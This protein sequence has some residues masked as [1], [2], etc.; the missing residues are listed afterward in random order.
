MSPTPEQSK[1]IVLI[2]GINGYIASQCAKAFLEAGYSVRGTV[3]QLSSAQHLFT[4]AFTSYANAGKFEVAEVRDITVPGAFD[5]AVKGVSF[6]LHAASP[7]G[8]S[9][10]DP[11]PILHTAVVGT[12]T[13]LE[14]A[15]EHAGPQLQSVIVMSSI[16]AITT[17]A[18]PPYTYTEKDWNNWA[19]KIVQAK[20]K[21]TPGSVIY[22]ASKAAAEKAFW[23]FKEEK[24][25]AWS[26]VS[27]N[28]VYVQQLLLCQLNDTRTN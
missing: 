27:I 19:E 23:K 25:P 20:G 12:T 2:S 6:I 4:E 9:F 22:V 28:P 17:G 21:D 13:I 5:E 8:L 7:L 24:K 15:Y 16:A 10:T 3:R 26:M 1:G 18:E 14:S 11:E